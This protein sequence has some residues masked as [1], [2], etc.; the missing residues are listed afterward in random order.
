[1]DYQQTLEY[2][3]RALPMYQRIGKSAYKKNLD[4]TLALC[5][6]LG[7]PQNKFKTVHVAGTNGKGSSSHM[8]SAILQSAGYKTGLYTSPH[9]K[10]FTERI[11]IDG[12]QITQQAVIDFVND[13]KVLIEEIKPSFFEITV[14]MAFDYF[15]RQFVDIA[16]I[17][18]G[19]GG[20]LDSTNVISP[21]VSLI[22]NIGLDHQEMLG[23]TLEA[24]A[25]EKAGII[26]KKVPVV[27]GKR[28]P[29]TRVVFEKAAK[30]LNSPIIFAEEAY[31][32]NRNSFELQLKGNYQHQNVSG[33]LAVVNLLNANGFNIS[34]DDIKYGLANT[35]DLTGIKGR[36]QKLQEQ[37]LMICDT[38]HNVDGIQMI[39]KQILRIPHKELHI[40][41]GMVDD[42]DSRPMLSLL[43][44]DGKY[45]FCQANVPRA[46]KAQLLYEEAGKFGFKGEIVEDVNNAIAAAKQQANKDD[47]I[48]IGGSTFV[49]AEI[50]DL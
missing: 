40:V 33:V 28:Q 10:S 45:Y 35:V 26:K 5:E 2:L 7:N 43:P 27:I 34:S 1:M 25:V 21:E 12:D 32:N 46:K 6:A 9:L 19:L 49:I 24:I 16:V 50:A 3:F 23:D 13:H 8:L 29:E 44:K 42:K 41:W 17:E 48:F 31:S 30:K 15:A 18:V 37:P 38:G 39:L 47:L 14:A 4:N 22:T 11:R 20:R 36:W